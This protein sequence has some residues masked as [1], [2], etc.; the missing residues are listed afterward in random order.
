MAGAGL[1]LW[2][3]CPSG[4]AVAP[5]ALSSAG[6]HG[7][8]ALTSSGNTRY[9]WTIPDTACKYLCVIR[10]IVP[11]VVVLIVAAC[12][13]SSTTAAAP[14]AV[15]VSPSTTSTAANPVTILKQTG[16]TVPAGTVYGDHDLYGDRDASGTFPGGE[17]VTVYTS[18]DEQAFLAEEGRPQVDDS[19][20]V[21]TIPSKL[22]VI[23]VDAG[24]MSGWG[25]PT[26]AQI[27]TRVHGLV[28]QPQQ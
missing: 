20:G 16:A 9:N 1:R 4:W 28:Q 25:G 22:A 10:R 11:A 14:P 7:V 27:A 19:H 6:C 12:S 24:G 8:P 15:P 2:E 26:P 21:V 13:S 3:R 18:P 5:S 23:A 17:S